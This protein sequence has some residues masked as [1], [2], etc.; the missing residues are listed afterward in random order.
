MT[1]FVT[2][3]RLLSTLACAVGIAGT[4]AAQQIR[5]Y[6]QT[7]T[8]PTLL[9]FGLPVPRPIESLTPVDGFRSYASLDARLQG[10]A[11]ASDDLSAHDIGRTFAGRPHWAYVVSDADGI[12]VEG[13]P[14]AAFFINATTHAREWG[15]PEV[16]TGTIERLVAGANDGGLTRYL[17]DNTRL[18]TI[19]VHNIDGLL[20]AQ[21]FPTD[22]I[23]GQDPNST[24]SPRDGRMRRK[25][26]RG[27]DEVLTTFADHLNGVDLN[28]NHPP[29]WATSS[30][31]SSNPAELRF[32][33]S[34]PHSEPESM[35]LR[36]AAELGPA[37]RFRLGI[38]VHTYSRVFFSSN[39]ARTRLNEIQRRL[40]ANLT[41]HH[42]Q[43]SG[44]LYI[45]KPDPPNTGIGAAAEYFAY[46]WLVPSWTL[47][48]EPLN[49]A[50]EYGGTAVTHGG[51][52][53]P[54]SEA[55]RVR[56]SWAETH[57]VAF[58]IMAGPPHL[59]RVRMYD[60]Q[61]GALAQETRW[62]YNATS[63]QRALQTSVPGSLQPGRRYRAELAFSKPMRRRDA[64]G[65][66]VPL[67][68][69]FITPQPQ[70]ALLNGTQRQPLDVAGGVWLDEPTRVMRYRG[71]TFAFEFTAPVNVADYR[72]EVNV[73]DMTGLALDANPSTPV[74]WSAGAWSEWEDATGVDG[75]V[76]GA[77]TGT[78]LSVATATASLLEIVPASRL[79]GE[80]DSGLLRLRLAQSNTRR[81]DAYL[82]AYDGTFPGPSL[83]AS[84]LPGETGE[85][86]VLLPF[87]ENLDA[88]GDR[89]VGV[90]FVEAV[91]GTFGA[92]HG[93]DY[94]VL[95]NDASDHVVFRL[96]QPEEL[97][98][99]WSLLRSGAPSRRLVLDGNLAYEV[100]A[101]TA[102]A[103]D[104]G[105]APLE[106]TLRIYG[107]G[108]TLRLSSENRVAPLIDVAA[109]GDLW[110]DRLDV[111][112]APA[113]GNNTQSVIRNAGLLSMQRVRASGEFRLS[114]PGDL[115]ENHGD[116]RIERSLLHGVDTRCKS[117]I[118]GR[119]GSLSFTTSTADTNLIGAVVGVLGGTT[120]LHGLSLIGN[121]S[122]VTPIFD[123]SREGPPQF[124][125]VLLQEN[126]AYVGR[127]LAFSPTPEEQN[128]DRA[129]SSLGF[130][131]ENYTACGFNQ[132]SDRSG[133]DL[134]NFTFD[135]AL[136][137]Y[138]PIG[139]AIDGGAT[140]AQSAATGCGPVDQRG[141]PRPQTLTPGAAPRCDI[142]AIELGVNP[143]RGI[144]QPDRAGHG[145]DIQTAG[146]N[147]FL[148]WYTYED[149]GEPTAY[150][151]VA[152]LTGPHWEASLQV[153]SRNPQT[154]QITQRTVGRVT[155]D[156]TSDTDAR[157]GWRF[158]ARG[159]TG[160]ERIRPS[161]FA[162]G[163]PRFEVTGLWYPP[164]DA[165]YGA[166]ISRRGEITAVGLYYYD[167]QGNIRWALG[168]SN[169]TD[170][171]EMPMTSYTGF[172]P[173][174]NA[175]T[176]PVTGRPAGTM[177]A[178]FHTPERARLDM[179]LTYPGAAGGVW[180][181]QRARFVPINDPV[182]NRYPLGTVP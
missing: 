155:L 125:H 70:V 111:T 172:C 55:R 170:A 58:Y 2:A 95:D 162:P 62:Q 80:G 110:L 10:L 13:R 149:D 82:Y 102:A 150:Q 86:G 14:E 136:G 148:A 123:G 66:I 54:A 47:E 145:V 90:R 39:T 132:P 63:A 117:L 46:E 19:P 182:D 135:A 65:A 49:D 89:D 60:V 166:T 176:M 48:L 151:A 128:C 101:D 131:I 18:V 109:A 50:T 17:L 77:D 181:K 53:L 15:A 108:A 105:F 173:D 61:S 42:E 16:S 64:T 179:Q 3:G 72:L 161:L 84:W 91:D 159:T 114:S 130:N 169:G 4:A 79:V 9:T 107:N 76:G 1:G 146:N 100:P 52:I 154:G 144:W 71:D 127:C 32:H 129:G 99:V 94:R 175:A 74:D 67:P 40:L 103:V 98:G 118:G 11:L 45:D 142:G 56:E 75:D 73:L 28:R 97:P 96:R 43:V 20:Q 165:G 167:S 116:L 178:H 143:Y 34:G 121:L 37:T 59:V 153:S 112:S 119:S 88:D 138:A 41:T 22:V 85:R 26:M 168:T 171:F 83:I 5:T 141:A 87:G 174:C 93:V 158:D 139:S 104:G 157:L 25:N 35:A 36:R 133:I 23:V 140:A 12:D 180:N 29:F 27:V 6:T 126:D 31:S 113:S 57:V 164:D 120:R 115:I 122:D 137:G 152:P 8:G 69:L 78:P 68:G 44:K 160:S 156:F 30:Q 106:S 177:L 81:I 21:R 124:G 51:F 7:Q 33:G 24:T 163:Q 92:S 147:L 38:D 134:G